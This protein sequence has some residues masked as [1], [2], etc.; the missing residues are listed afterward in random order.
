MIGVGDGAVSWGR[1][2]FAEWD[3]RTADMRSGGLTT[4]R[5]CRANCSPTVAHVP[6]TP[7]DVRTLAANVPERW[8]ALHLLHRT[9]W[10]EIEAWLQ[11]GELQAQRRSDGFTRHERGAPPSHWSVR[12]LEP[13]YNSYLWS[14]ML[15]PYELSHHVDIE[16][17]RAERLHGR[18]VCRFE[19]RARD[20]YD[21]ICPCCPLVFS[22]VSQ[23]LEHGEGWEPD[24]VRLPDYC[25]IALDVE[26]GI[27]ASRHEVGGSTDNWFENEI[28]SAV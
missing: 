7:D 11:H 13:I 15:D 28:V 2:R 21:P 9:S 1:T 3:V 20:G 10:D 19:A 12:P 16:H 17:V 18:T 27:V 24:E 22:L 26:T 14:A 4:F 8:T 23:R 5:C 25:E 6:T